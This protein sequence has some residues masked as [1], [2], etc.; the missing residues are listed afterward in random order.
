V[1]AAAV[2]ATAAARVRAH[3][4]G[5]EGDAVWCGAAGC[6]GQDGHRRR[7]LV[8]ERQAQEHHQPEVEP[9]LCNCSASAG[10]REVAP[11]PR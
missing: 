6:V 3:G 11:R 8:R 1:L 7:G 5:E 4:A 10:Y 9:I 2:L